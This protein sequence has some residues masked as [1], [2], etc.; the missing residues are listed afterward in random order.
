MGS[1]SITLRSVGERERD[2]ERDIASIESLL[3]ANDLPNDDV[4][5]KP[6]AFYI[7]SDGDERVGIGGLERC[8]SDA[9]L[10]SL[11]VESDVRSDGY[12]T[13]ICEALET[14]GRADGIE[15]LYVLTT[16]AAEFFADRGYERIDRADAPPAIRRTNEFADLCPSTATCLRRSL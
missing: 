8:G 13:A 7:A 9:L 12:G 10:R 3:E 16:T 14:R 4:R 5:E 2:R 1:A 11:V 6:E 15:T